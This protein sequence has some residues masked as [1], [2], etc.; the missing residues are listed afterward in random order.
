M[1]PDRYEGLL[2]P[3]DFSA[4]SAD[5]LRHAI[6]I[7]QRFGTRLT[8]LHV[9][10][11]GFTPGESRYGG[12]RFLL[13]P[14]IR[15]HAEEG[16]KNFLQPVRDARMDH[17]VELREG[18]PS[19]EIL[20]CANDGRVDLVVMGARGASGFERL[21]LGSVAE[22]VVHRVACD[23]LTVG[24]EEGRTW[25]A[26]GLISRIVCGVDFSQA[27]NVAVGRAADF[28][29]AFG[30]A[31]TLVHVIES[32]PY[33]AGDIFGGFIE[34]E[35]MR[36]SLTDAAESGLKEL[37]A[38]PR[39]AGLKVES[40]VVT[41]A[42]AAPALVEAAVSGNADL[43]V[44]GAQGH[45]A[46]ERFLFGSTSRQVIRRATCPVLSVRPKKAKDEAGAKVSGGLA[47]APTPKRD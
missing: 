18:D 7:A 40:R 42:S 38:D 13:L 25:D 12:T 28:A 22:K 32:V 47:L 8:V 2:C 31:M 19:R 44:V 30:A 35:A 45:G 15:K 39:L 10:P 1:E 17:M 33:L 34:P 21:V 23:V 26:P 9:I 20:A 14:E 16:M 6:A 27:S 5:A 46:V 29:R 37:L 3:T 36:K 43:L 4:F 11:H 24:H 41:A